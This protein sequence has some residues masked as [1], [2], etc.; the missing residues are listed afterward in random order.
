M[1]STVLSSGRYKAAGIIVS[2]AALS[3][4][5]FPAVVLK[6]AQQGIELWAVSVLPAL[7]PFFICADIMISLGIPSL[8]G[9]VFEKPFQK[10]FGTPGSSA[11]VFIISITSGYPMGA[12][13][14]GQM[15]RRGDLTDRDGIRM[16]SFCSNSGPLFMLGTVGAGLLHSPEAGAVVASSH[17]AAAVINGLLFR[18]SEK[19]ET[20][21]RNVEK[22]QYTGLTGEKRSILDMLT[23][24][25]LSSVKTLFIICCYIII[26]TYA[27]DLLD[28]TGVFCGLKS[29]CNSGFIKGLLE[30][31]IGLND[32]S[33]SGD[34]GLRL[35]CTMS[36]FLVS[37]GGLSVMAQSMSVLKGLKIN[38]LTYLWIKLSHGIIAGLLAYCFAPF[39]LNRAVHD[40]GLFGGFTN[41]FQPG[42]LM[43]LLFSTKMII[44]IS[45]LFIL[46]VAIELLMSSGKDTKD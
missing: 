10:L 31:T 5:F 42:F 45:A 9:A 7:L 33:L 41:A 37:F 28:M 38:G 23:S 13:I 12:K 2:M 8:V 43:Q 3:M 19:K 39:F 20:D 27:T 34:A 22:N 44:I 21:G 32:I 29:Q 46:T 36:A 4:V 17:Y 6:S 26:F 14:I 11:F 24:S 25:M 15:R 1:K 40:V 18:I 30:M 35:K 16:L